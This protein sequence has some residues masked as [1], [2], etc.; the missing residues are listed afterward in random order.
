MF[1][2]IIHESEKMTTKLK[3]I[4]PEQLWIPSYGV[5]KFGLFLAIDYHHEVASIFYRSAIIFGIAFSFIIISLFQN[6][7]D[8]RHKVDEDESRDPTFEI[9]QYFYVVL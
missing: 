9:T 4:F 5:Q 1:D 6:F 3:S 8:S 2:S 7:F